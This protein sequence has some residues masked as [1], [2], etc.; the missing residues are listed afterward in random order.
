MVPDSPDV[1]AAILRLRQGIANLNREGRKRLEG[2]PHPQG[3]QAGRRHEIALDQHGNLVVRVH[4]REVL[5][6]VVEVDVD[7]LK[8]H[9]LLVQHD[10]AALAERIG[11]PGIER[12]HR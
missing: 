11:G 9:A 1:E 12:H 4:H 10:A 2:G 7:D 8:V 5:R 3:G 6:F